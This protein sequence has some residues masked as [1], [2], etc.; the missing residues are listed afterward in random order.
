MKE[1]PGRNV[2]TQICVTFVPATGVFSVL[3][4]SVLVKNKV[5]MQWQTR[6]KMLYFL[7]YSLGCIYFHNA[8]E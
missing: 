6:D 4:S 2:C 5:S 7:C 1:K 8:K 3:G